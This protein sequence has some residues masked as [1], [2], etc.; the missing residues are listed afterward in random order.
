MVDRLYRRRQFVCRTREGLHPEREPLEVLATIR[1]ALGGEYNLQTST[2]LRRR[3][4]GRVRAAW[5]ETRA[6]TE[7]PEQYN[8]VCRVATPPTS[9]QSSRTCTSWET[10]DN[11]T[12]LLH[13]LRRWLSYPELKRAVVREWVEMH[14]AT[15][16][17]IGDKPSG[18][19]LIQGL[20]HEGLRIVKAV[21][22]EGDK[23]MRFNAETATI[24]NG[25]VYLLRGAMLTGYLQEIATFPQFEVQRT[26]RFDLAG[27]RIVQAGGR[28]AG[29]HHP[30]SSEISPHVA[31]SAT[32][33]RSYPGK[34]LLSHRWSKW[35]GEKRCRRP[36]GQAD[37]PVR[38]SGVRRKVRDRA[39]PH[40][41]RKPRLDYDPQCWGKMS[42]WMRVIE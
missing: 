31:S 28:Q 33:A 4:E 19:E 35:F 25:F 12:Y 24:E 7:L 6:E 32:A 11:G 10:E 9:L 8:Q 34:S 37:H 14:R 17:L 5:C 39:Y 18:T 13:M 30:L 23:V 16:V 40:R 1:A 15:V 41:L 27:T 42:P 3:R 21:K 38:M 36:C 29:H 2:S 22:P 20:F 26:G